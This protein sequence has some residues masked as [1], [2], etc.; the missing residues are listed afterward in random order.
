MPPLW[1][2]LGGTLGLQGQPGRETGNRGEARG[3]AGV[4][5]IGPGRLLCGWP[6]LLFLGQK[7]KTERGALALIFLSHC[8]NLAER[9]A[10]PP[11]PGLG[12]LTPGWT[13]VQ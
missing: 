1:G 13:S 2:G 3:N 9:T 11:T 5:A 8:E 12:D 6:G 10:P 4:G 7:L